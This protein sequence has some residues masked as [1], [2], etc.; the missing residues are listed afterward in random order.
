MQ[1]CI[2][3]AINQFSSRNSFHLHQIAATTTRRVEFPIKNKGGHEALLG[4]I[5]MGAALLGL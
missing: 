1:G 5:P 2:L 3:L 4:E